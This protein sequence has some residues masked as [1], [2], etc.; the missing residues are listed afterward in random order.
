M[1]YTRIHASSDGHSHFEDVVMA[2]ETRRSPVSDGVSE[3]GTPIAASAVVLRRVV[4][5]HPSGPHVSPRR[6]F[7]VN[8]TSS[9]EVETSDGEVRRFGPGSF[10]LLED[11]HGIGHVTREI[12]DGVERTS[13]FIELPDN[14]PTGPQRQG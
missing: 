9:L 11:T 1:R 4:A 5:A 14:A 7:I 2:G 10:L 3:Y 13:M 6:Q 8:L 12:D